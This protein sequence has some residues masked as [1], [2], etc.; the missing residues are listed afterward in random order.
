MANPRRASSP[1][2]RQAPILG[3]IDT[4]DPTKVR[5]TLQQIAEIIDHP[6]YEVAASWGVEGSDIRACTLQVYDRRGNA[7]SGRYAVL[8][9]LSSTDGGAPSGSHS[10]G[11][12]SAG[13]QLLQLIANSAF[14]DCTDATG[15]I[16]VPVTVTGAASRTMMCGVVARMDQMLGR[17]ASWAA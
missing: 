11:A 13:S 1:A 10:V 8:W 15:K 5:Q 2:T 7:L 4:T 16:V 12:R 17:T 14:L 6:V 3:V 9:Y